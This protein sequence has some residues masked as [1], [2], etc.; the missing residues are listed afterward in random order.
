MATKPKKVQEILPQVPEQ[1]EPPANL[2]DAYLRFQRDVGHATFDSQNPHF[3]SDFASLK[4]VIDTVRPVLNR[5]GITFIQTS[6]PCDNGIAVETTFHG[7]GESIGTGPV[8]IPVDRANA[9]GF[10]SALSYAKRYSLSMACGIS[11]GGGE[12]DDGNSAAAN[13]PRPTSVTQTVIE[14]EGLEMDEEKKEDYLYRIED[15]FKQDDKNGCIELIQE[16]TE[17]E[18]LIVWNS[19]PSKARTQIRKWG[20]E[21]KEEGK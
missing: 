12:D 21:D 7:Y 3:K 15:A 9:H 14:Q 11:Q 16:L 8:P 2:M 20:N 4:Q 13:A 17:D 10:G 6:V 19:L 18:K 1:Q 5:H